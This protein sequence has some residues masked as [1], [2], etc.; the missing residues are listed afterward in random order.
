MK[1]SYESK[2]LLYFYQVKELFEAVVGACLTNFQQPVALPV[3]NGNA[4]EFTKNIKACDEA[5]ARIAIFNGGARSFADALL[6][7]LDKMDA[8]SH[9]EEK[10]NDSE[11]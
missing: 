4:D 10:K 11:T 3:S 5:N 2:D 8:E 6:K 7:E 1:K 9:E